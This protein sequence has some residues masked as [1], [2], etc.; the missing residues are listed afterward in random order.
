M[1]REFCGRCGSPVRAGARYCFWCGVRHPWTLPGVVRP[2][3]RT[4]LVAG[5]LAALAVGLVV[6]A[7][8]AL[9]Q[10]SVGQGMTTTYPNTAAGLREATVAFFRVLLEAEQGRNIPTAYAA[11]SRACREQ[12]TI[13]VFRQRLDAGRERLRR[14]YGVEPSDLT[15]TGAEVQEFRGG[16]GRA[17]A[18]VASERFSDVARRLNADAP[19]TSA[20]DAVY[21]DGNWRFALCKREG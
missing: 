3:E 14:D 4:A 20:I 5:A 10:G 19:H 2:R 12:W 15:V 16:A 11:L 13:D 17:Y 18:L 9:R 21:E 1:E 8:M 6:F 7:T